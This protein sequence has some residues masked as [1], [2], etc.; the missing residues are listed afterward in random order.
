MKNC[1]YSSNVSQLKSQDVSLFFSSIFQ[2]VTWFSVCSFFVG[3]IVNEEVGN[4]TSMTFAL[5]EVDMQQ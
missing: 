2:S 5:A 3:L 1:F 4:G